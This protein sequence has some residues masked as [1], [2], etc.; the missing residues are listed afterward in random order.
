MQRNLKLGLLQKERR[1]AGGGLLQ[2][3]M[4]PFFTLDRGSGDFKSSSGAR[5]PPPLLRLHLS[6]TLLCLCSMLT[7]LTGFGH[8]LHT[9]DFHGFSQDASLP[10]AHFSL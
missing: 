2:E 8:A 3:E 7:H 10:L 9:P 1:E 6:V 4:I 5:H